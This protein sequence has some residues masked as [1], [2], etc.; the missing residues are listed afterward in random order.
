[1]KEFMLADRDEILL[2]IVHRELFHGCLSENIG[3]A[4][5]KMGLAVFLYHY[6]RYTGNML[7]ADFAGELIEEIC[8]SVYDGMALSFAN[9]LSGIGWGLEYLAKNHFVEIDDNSV[10]E[11]INYKILEIN[12]DRMRDYSL[13]TGLEGIWAYVHAHISAGRSGNI[14]FSPA[15]IQTL[16]RLCV[17]RTDDVLW[18][19]ILQS[20]KFD[21]LSW[22][23]GLKMLWTD[24]CN[25]G[26]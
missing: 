3:L 6:S 7:F 8:E 1:M 18:C 4:S 9:G 12:P 17:L 5:G 15:F 16:N 2:Q 20:G 26:K 14:L 25:G 24:I 11:D 19:E 10:F 23:N 13:A 21:E 22:Q